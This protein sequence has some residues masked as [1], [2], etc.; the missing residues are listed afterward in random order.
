MNDHEK[1]ARENFEEETNNLKKQAEAKADQI[2]GSI[3]ETAGKMTDDYKLQSE[4]TVDKA[5]GRIKEEQAERQKR[6]NDAAEAARKELHK[7]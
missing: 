7:D 2:K 6:V 5:A 3:K 4:G 1:T